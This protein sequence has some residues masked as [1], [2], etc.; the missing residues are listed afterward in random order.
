MNKKTLAGIG[1]GLLTFG[2]GTITADN[3]IDPYTSN[4]TKLEVV[5]QSTLKDSGENKIEVS[6]TEPAVTLSK[7]DGETGIT[8]KYDKVKAIGER[9]FLTN[10]VEWKGNKEE[11]HAYPIQAKAG[12]EDGGFE[13]EVILNEKPD[14]NVFD[15]KIENAEN[16]DFFYQPALT[17]Q[18]IDRGASRPENVIGSYAVYHKDKANHLTGSTNYATGKV[19][20]IY[21]PKI[22]DNSGTEVWGELSYS[23]GVLTV[24]VPQG[25]LD[26]ANYP[27][28]VDPTFGYTSQGASNI[29]LGG[30]S[31][32]TSTAM[33]GTAVTGSVTSLSGYFRVS[34]ISAHSYQLRLLNESLGVP[35]G[36]VHLDSGIIGLS[37]TSYELKTFVGSFDMVGADYWI[38]AEGPKVGAFGTTEQAYDTGGV[39]GDG[40]S[41]LD[42]GAWTTDSNRY[43]MYVTY[44]D[45]ALPPPP[46]A[47]INGDVEINANIN[48]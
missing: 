32:D 35:G 27:V 15:F 30:S 16:L 3:I 12:M 37:N 40:A 28:R 23:N 9:A 34:S 10:R 26:V 19:Y 44:G 5:S 38:N 18:E 48:I 7:W 29:A 4:G 6:K 25:F 17:Q 8:V 2:G 45:V 41:R 24:T 39:S 20:H 14:T 36:T 21:R 42:F 43:S 13:I 33:Q 47:Q 11:V 22:I 1:A 46:K 31:S